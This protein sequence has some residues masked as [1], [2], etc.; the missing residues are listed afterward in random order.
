MGIVN[1]SLVEARESFNENATDTT[2][3]QNSII[4][5]GKFILCALILLL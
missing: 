5:Q 1:T 3:N 4:Y 2:I